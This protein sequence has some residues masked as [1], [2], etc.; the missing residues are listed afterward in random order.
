MINIIKMF[1]FFAAAFSFFWG[2]W[3]YGVGATVLFTLFAVLFPTQT[4][5]TQGHS[6]TNS[7]RTSNSN[8]PH[9]KSD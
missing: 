8:N 2:G 4:E 6:E 3:E 5:P 9:Q 1:V 7:P